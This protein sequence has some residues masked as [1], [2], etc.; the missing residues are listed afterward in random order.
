V[1]WKIKVPTLKAGQKLEN[2]LPSY[3]E[4]SKLQAGDGEIRVEIGPARVHVFEVD[5]PNIEN[6]TNKVY[7]Q[8]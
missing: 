5:T 7:K 3:G 8:K 2:L 6:Y 1:A 4:T